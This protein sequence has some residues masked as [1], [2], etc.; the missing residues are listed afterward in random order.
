M[1]AWAPVMASSSSS[2][3]SP[4]RTSTS[5]PACPEQLQA[6]V[7]DLFGDED[8]GHGLPSLSRRSRGGQPVTSPLMRVVVVGAGIS[9]LPV[10]IGSTT[11]ASTSSV[12]ERA[13][14]PGG[15]LATERFGGAVFDTDAEFF[16]VRTPAFRL[17]C[18]TSWIA[19][20][21]VR[22]W[23]RGF[24]PEPDG[25]PRVHRRRGD[26]DDRGGARRRGSTFTSASRWPT[27]MRSTPTR[28]VVTAPSDDYDEMRP[29]CCTCS[30]RPSLVPAPGGVQLTD[31][32]ILGFVADNHVKGISPVPALTLHARPR[33]RR[34][35]RRRGSV[36]RGRD[37]VVESARAAYGARAGP[38]HHRP[39]LRRQPT[40]RG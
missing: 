33:V 6:A 20:G 13:P 18:A 14:I 15:R 32:P 34:D 11:P 40:A 38:H 23:C 25:F 22:E 16:T 21:I 17:V 39:R 1:S 9:G 24:G 12:L 3:D 36:H 2:G 7:G 26:G 30:T 29:C 10:R 31:D 28:V 5:W 35:C 8:T 19:Y 4:S 27:S 37:R